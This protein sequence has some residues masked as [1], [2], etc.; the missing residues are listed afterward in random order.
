[1]LDAWNEKRKL[2][3]AEYLKQLDANKLDLPHVPEW[4]DPVWH[5]FVVR[6]AH[7][8]VLQAHLT[9]QGVG[10]MIHYP[11][12]PHMQPA[13][14]DLGIK[15]GY[16]LIAEAIH[17]EVLSLPMFPHMTTEQVGRVVSA[18]RNGTTVSAT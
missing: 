1:M 15:Q 6:S 18:C 8:E 11:I 3:A 14:A 13:Y 4:S 16:L 2:I 7:R 17:N 9:A 12:P 10:T 5:L